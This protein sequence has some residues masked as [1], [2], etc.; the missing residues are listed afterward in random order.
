MG[1]VSEWDLRVLRED[2]GPVRGGSSSEPSFPAA[3]QGDLAA[4]H[5]DD[6]FGAHVQF[7]DLE[8]SSSNGDYRSRASSLPEL[9]PGRP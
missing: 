6:R 7:T 4:V 5:R 3:A 9:V 8:Q 1:G 2:V